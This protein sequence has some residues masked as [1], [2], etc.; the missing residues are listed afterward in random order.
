MPMV[1]LSAVVPIPDQRQFV[2]RDAMTIILNGN[3]DVLAGD[4]L[5]N[6]YFLACAGVSQSV[7]QQVVDDLADAPF[8]SLDGII[9]LC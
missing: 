3:A 4:G 6:R 2:R 1:F 9:M 8:V 7:A 5:N